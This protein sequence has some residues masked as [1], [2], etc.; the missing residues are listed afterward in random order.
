SSGSFDV[1]LSF[2]KPGTIKIEGEENLLEYIETNVENDVLVIKF[3][4][5]INVNHRKKITVYVPLTKMSRLSL[6]GSG[7]I[8]GAGD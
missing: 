3:R 6:S 5:N 8:S 7:N 1:A 4:K 2:G